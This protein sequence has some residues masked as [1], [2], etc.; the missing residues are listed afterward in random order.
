[1]SS[2]SEDYKFYHDP[3]IVSVPIVVTIAILLLIWVVYSEQT[4]WE[5]L[6]NQIPN[7]DC[8][9]LTKAHI[10]YNYWLDG[11]NRT[12][13]FFDRYDLFDLWYDQMGKTRCIIP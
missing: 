5:N 9:E 10:R 12:Y 2:N 6:K 1:M 4:E 11:D 7:M 13:L 8:K 3:I